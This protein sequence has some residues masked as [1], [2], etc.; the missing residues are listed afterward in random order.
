MKISILSS[1]AIHPNDTSKKGQWDFG[2]TKDYFWGR[3]GGRV[4]NQFDYDD[5]KPSRL[6]F[7]I[8]QPTTPSLD[9]LSLKD[10]KINIKE[11]NNKIVLNWYFKV[12]SSPQLS[13]KVTVKN[14]YTSTQTNTT[15]TKPEARLHE[16]SGLSSG[17]YTISLKITDIFGQSIIKTY[18]VDKK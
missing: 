4:N 14:Q 18:T 7:E 12:N 17:K 13:Y 10:S 9:V 11:E 8:T 1:S 5:N 16:I 6:R 2:A 3:A 15:F